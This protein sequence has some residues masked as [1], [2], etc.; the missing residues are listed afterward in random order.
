MLIS[1][2][3]TGK[4]LLEPRQTALE[5]LQWSH[6]VLYQEIFLPKVTSVLE[7]CRKGETL[8]WFSNFLGASFY[9]QPQG[10]KKYQRTF[11]YSQ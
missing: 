10:D 1:A 6:I 3:R 7:H 5:M 9:L 2:E 8:F 4:S 11:L